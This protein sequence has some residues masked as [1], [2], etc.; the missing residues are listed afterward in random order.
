ML[1][2]VRRWLTIVVFPTLLGPRIIGSSLL[3]HLSLFLDLEGAR[4]LII[5]ISLL[6][7]L[8]KIKRHS[9]LYQEITL[10]NISKTLS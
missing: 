9:Y 10:N 5:H 3:A 2:W 4:S 7:V 1:I 6:N 8:S